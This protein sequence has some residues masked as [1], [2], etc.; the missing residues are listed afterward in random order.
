MQFS[1]W[2]W[3]RILAF[4][5]GVGLLFFAPWTGLSPALPEW[6]I[7]VLLSVPFGLCIYGFTEQPR[8]VIVQVPVGTVLGI[9]ILALYRASGVLLF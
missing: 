2:R 4:F 6:T 5:G 7:D 3:N 1:T 8:K 9:G